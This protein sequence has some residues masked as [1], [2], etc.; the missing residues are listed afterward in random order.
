MKGKLSCCPEHNFLLCSLK[1]QGVCKTYKEK[2]SA[3][4]LV[5][6]ASIAD[7]FK[8]DPKT[9]DDYN[10]LERDCSESGW[11]FTR[12]EDALI[13]LET[14]NIVVNSPNNASSNIFS[15]IFPETFF[16]PF[17]LR[18]KS[19]INENNYQLRGS[20]FHSKC[21]LS[22]FFSMFDFKKTG[23]SSDSTLSR[24]GTLR[25][26]IAMDP[27][28]HG[29]HIN[30]SSEIEEVKNRFNIP[31]GA[32]TEVPVEYVLNT[33]NID[34][35]L[36]EQTYP[37]EKNFRRYLKSFELLD[38]EPNLPD[39]LVLRG[40]ADCVL[41]LYNHDK[42]LVIL[43]LK[44]YKHGAYEHAESKFQFLSYGL[45]IQQKLNLDIDNFV[46]ISQHSPSEGESYSIR[47]PMYHI[48]QVKL[49]DSFIDRL[50]NEMA[51]HYLM[52]RELINNPEL[53]EKIRTFQETP[54]KRK[55]GKNK[56][57]TLFS[58]FPCIL[59]K[60]HNPESD[61]VGSE[62]E[63]GCGYCRK[64]LDLLC[65]SDDMRQYLIDGVSF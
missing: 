28:K 62:S 24:V 2:S 42:T 12:I 59:Y 15:N 11:S 52:K 9:S 16:L 31:T 1:E 54:T 26:S 48:T 14:S 32:W 19:L 7:L 51:R 34:L 45:A 36:D 61:K 56:C 44:R 57:E 6:G 13:H 41:K 29:T 23:I 46:L 4:N 10:N 40:T 17:D 43:D 53:L 8:K 65:N 25:H 3:T 39:K 5:C 50:H 27:S 35:D 20:E 21:P 37:E 63:K 30:N 47:P 18:K 60:S 64:M 49:T 22:Y 38:L 33:K 55:D 58:G